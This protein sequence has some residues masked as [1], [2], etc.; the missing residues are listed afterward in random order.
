MLMGCSKNI[1]RGLLISVSLTSYCNASAYYKKQMFGG[2]PFQNSP[3]SRQGTSSAY[4]TPSP[5]N[6]SPG[7]AQYSPAEDASPQ[8]GKLDLDVITDLI[9]QAEKCV[10]D[11]ISIERNLPTRVLV[12]GVT[13][14]G[15]STLV[16]S[17]AGKE[18]I[19]DKEFELDVK[20][21][22]YLP[23]LKIGH[24]VDSATT[25]PRSWYD[26]SNNLVYWDCPG[27]MDSRG[28]GQEI[29]NAF[30]IDQIF[31]KP[32]RIKIILAIQENELEGERGNHTLNRLRKVLNILPDIKTVK[33]GLTIVVTH[34][35]DHRFTA[36]KKLQGLLEKAKASNDL[37]NKDTI[38][39]ILA[40]LL[41]KNNR[42]F[43]F[44]APTV[45]GGGAYTLFTDKQNVLNS[46]KTPPVI[47][48]HHEICLDLNVFWC[49]KEMV[50]NFADIPSL[51]LEFERVVQQHYRAPVED[52]IDS[53]SSTANE[54]TPVQLR[55]LRGQE[56]SRLKEWKKFAAALARQSST[57]TPAIVTPKELAIAVKSNLPGYVENPHSENEVALKEDLYALVGSMVTSQSY[58]DFADRIDPS[59]LITFQSGNIPEVLRS[60]L[61]G[62]NSELDSLIQSKEFLN[63]QEDAQIAL[64]EQLDKEV[65][66]GKIKDAERQRQIEKLRVEAESERKSAEEKLSLMQSQ[67]ERDRAQA[68]T[69]LDSAMAAQKK[70]YDL[71]MDGMQNQIK[72]AENRAREAPSRSSSCA[73]SSGL[74]ALMQMM[75][76]GGGGM[77][78]G[79]PG[80]SMGGMDY[81][82]PSYASSSGGHRGSGGHRSSMST[83]SSGHRTWV[84]P[85]IRTSSS[86]RVSQVKGHYRNY[87]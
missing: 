3:S 57:A 1:I 71:K 11:Q 36:Q 14:S 15:K 48:P 64:K 76:M 66:E 54:L 18:L 28:E 23:G 79:M 78:G 56:L 87:K 26:Q 13:G 70:E 16:H 10:S 8:K 62:M 5:G 65:A 31:T 4:Q 53:N 58:F 85:H 6:R 38:T 43:T 39:S 82:V 83:S 86:G 72:E 2:S 74:A 19:S 55:S 51:I 7:S 75:S 59:G 40:D 42:I 80:Y 50:R 32:S 29:V 46:L 45:V 37:I 49:V 69:A 63:Q 47:N 21:K 44:P 35:V 84:A 61:A 33:D 73:D 17:L 12:L 20:G 52:S 67:L 81:S 77:G 68:K 34:K 60:L 24:G 25:I 9:V 41:Q 30:S 22:D 27:F